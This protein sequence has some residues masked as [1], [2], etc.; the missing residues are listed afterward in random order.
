IAKIDKALLVEGQGDVVTMHMHGFG[1]TVAGSGTAFGAHQAK[2]IMR[3]TRNITTMYDGDA[4]GRKATL[5]TL[6]VLLGEGANVRIISLPEGEDPDTF[7]PKLDPQKGAMTLKAMEQD[8]VDYLY[9]IRSEEAGKDVYKKEEAITELAELFSLIES[10]IVRNELIKKAAILWKIGANDITSKIKTQK[11]E[12]NTDSWK[13]GFYGIDEARGMLDDDEDVTL[14]FN[15]KEFI[16]NYDSK[17]YV[18]A[19]GVISKHDVQSF[20]SALKKC[21]VQETVSDISID[22][23]GNEP[24]NLQVLKEMYRHKI[25][26]TIEK[27]W[28]DS[29]GNSG[30]NITG[31]ADYYISSYGFLIQATNCT[32]TQKASYIKKCAEIIS[33]AD[34]TVR[35]VSSKS[36]ASVLKITQANLKEVVQPL[37][38]LKKDKAALEN[39]RLN[40]VSDLVDFDPQNN[41]EVPQYVDDDPVLSKIYKRDR[42]YPLIKR[43][44]SKLLPIAY[45]F[46]NEKGGGHTCIS[47]F[48]ME[49]LLHIK[50][51]ESALNKRVVQLNHIHMNPCFMEI[52]SSMMVNLG[53]LNEKF[54]EEGS[55]NFDGS[56][57]QWK[58]IWRNMSYKFT[59]CSELRTFGQQPEEFWA[60]TNAILHEVEGEIKIE[61]TNHLGVASHN[62]LNYY[63]PAFSEIFAHQRRDDDQYELDRFFIYKEVP[64]AQRIDFAEWATLMN[65]VYKIN[66]NG[67]WAILFSML[68]CFRDYIFSNTR[69]FTTLFFIGPTGS[70]KSQ[71]AFSMRSLFMS[72]DAPVFNLNS[73]TDAAF[74]MLLERNKNVL[75]IMEEY[76]DTS[77]SQVKFQG[78]KASVLDGQGRTKIKDM[79]NKTLDSSKINAVPLILGQEAPQQD[80]GSLSNRVIICDVPYNPNGEFTEEEKELFLRL[81]GHEKAGLQNVLIE[82]LSLRKTIKDHYV[83]IFNAEVKKI[84]TEIRMNVTNNEGLDRVINSVGMLSAMCLLIEKHTTLKLP[85]T[86]AEFFG[87]ACAKILKQME[88]ISSSNKLSTFFDNISFLI[89]QGSLKIGKELKVTQTTGKVTRLVSGRTEEVLLEPVETRVLYLDFKSIYPLYNRSVKDSLS[90]ASLKSYFESNK[91]FLG[92]CKSTIFRWNET[93]EVPRKVEGVETLII[94][95]L[96]DK[97]TNNTS[98]YMFN[99][100]I[101]ADLMGVD[102]ERIDTEVLPNGEDEHVPEKKEDVP[103]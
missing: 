89:N 76:N 88:V 13:D 86:Y 97:K 73:G 11:K 91:A 94:D 55:Y 70:G 92:L 63:S 45:M 48:Y 79:N 40:D 44:E 52:Q 56:M 83:S 77:I 19:K 96:I 65:Q 16:D 62:G 74:F 24:E 35:T 53:K 7:A 2:Q 15:E 27:G 46:H 38:N 28:K 57:N 90:Q 4:A 54:A 30:T 69:F 101:L 50:H 78:L 18:L 23:H 103:F 17:P 98:A 93:K 9:Q 14:T 31:F 34:V 41:I 21:I 12:L 20:H 3:F 81:K 47:D 68:S 49:P 8:M 82:V 85:F 39:Q 60:W 37:L 67:K 100:D 87:L 5:A 75:S 25:E 99:Y 72:P 22:E 29:D 32:E 61:Y 33:C 42:F 6:R 71:V 66:D 80:D 36:W 43:T 10:E 102:Y 95:R 26:I 1:H 51:K 58:V 64:E 84:N 59:T